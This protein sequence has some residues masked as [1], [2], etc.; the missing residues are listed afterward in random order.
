MKVK[1]IDKTMNQFRKWAEDKNPF[2]AAVALTI[3][4]LSKEYYELSE[5]VRIGKRLEGDIPL[6]S[7]N[8]WLNLY[9]NPKRISKVLFNALGVNNN[10]MAKSAQLKTELVKNISSD[11][12]KTKEG[13][14][15][16]TDNYL[17]LAINDFTSEIN[18]DA[19]KEFL[20]N[21]KKPEIMF[22]I[23]VIAPCFSIYGTYPLDLIKK[24]KSGDDKALEQLIRLDKSIIFEPKISEIIH[25]AQVMKNQERMLKIKKAFRSSTKVM[26]MKTIKCYV[27]GLISLF[28]TELKQ[29]IN[30]S[31][32]KL[33]YD[34][35]SIDMRIDR[36]DQDL[37]QMLS[38]AFQKAI[39]RAHNMWRIILTPDK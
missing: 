8:T 34:A 4:R 14:D 26:S 13:S 7:L 9:R 28:S 29:K 21:L 27:G 5:S 19:R 2:V 6:P 30:P 35:I 25:Q 17:E 38:P 33:L 36:H 20:I 22:F 1:V 37:H 18:E 15:E 12:K 11:N 23:R 3:A 10:D 31:D 24:A 32:I 39:K 16:T